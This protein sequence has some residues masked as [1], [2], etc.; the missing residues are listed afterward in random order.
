M[1]FTPPT[2]DYAP[3]LVGATATAPAPAE[4]S[5]TERSL[6]S[7]VRGF[8]NSA[9][10]HV[11]SGRT[12][13]VE[14]NLAQARELLAQLP[15]HAAAPWHAQIEEISGLLV[16]AIR[17]EAARRVTG[18]LN[19]QLSKADADIAMLRIEPVHEAIALVTR[20]LGDDDVRG[21][22]GPAEVAAYQARADKLLDKLANSLKA[23]ALDRV[24]P[25]LAELEELTA[26]DPYVGLEALQVRDK[27]QNFAILRARAIGALRHVPDSDPDIRALVARIIA[28]DRI[29]EN[30]AA[31]WGKAELDEQVSNSGESVAQAIAGWQD[32]SIESDDPSQLY[33]P[34]LPQTRA[35]IQRTRILLEDSETRRIRA[36][37]PTDATIQA[38]YREAERVFA[39]AAAKLAAA[40]GRVLDVADGMEPPLDQFLLRAPSQL[41]YGAAA[42]FE[43]SPYQ[44]SIVARAQALDEHWKAAVA[45]VMKARQ[46][47]YDKLAGE[48]ELHWPRLRETFD[49]APFDRYVAPGMLVRLDRIYNRCGWDYGSRA[50]DFAARVDGV[51]IGG[52]YSAHVR[53]ALEYAWYTLKLDVND[54]IPW[55]LIAVVEGDDKIGVRTQVTLRD[56]STGAKLGELEQWP[57]VDCVRIRIIGLHAGPVSVAQTER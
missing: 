41:A 32:E 34:T 44:A 45:A 28:V 11:E 46:D 48:A 9:R 20:R 19:R 5:D 42:V 27:A 40:Y 2:P 6:V 54:R 17:S 57:L 18:E 30:A 49:V 8:V 23:D 25:L 3:V 37:H 36:E 50:F 26:S 51:L 47:L 43:G 22:L 21:T 39:D 12:D 33:A 24:Q 31:R 14:P 1:P 16:E 4:L 35:A 29:V 13:N 38:P 56:R 52:T 53:A 10:S 55:D 7:R 15:A